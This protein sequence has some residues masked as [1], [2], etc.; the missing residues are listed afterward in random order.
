MRNVKKGLIAG[1]VIFAMSL[2]SG[3]AQKNEIQ[4]LDSSETLCETVTG[5]Q[6]ENLEDAGH[7]AYVEIVLEEAIQIL[8]VKEGCS[9]EE[10]EKR[11]AE[12]NFSIY[13]NFDQ[14]IYASMKSTYE[15]YQEN[16][17]SFASAVT[18]LNGKLIAAYSGGES[19]E[20]VNYVTT[21]TPPY[22]SFKPLSV[23]TPAIEKG[24]TNWSKAYEDSPVK[25]VEDSGGVLRDWPANAT[26][27]YTNEDMLVCEA[28]K[29]ST[30]TVA[31]KCLQEYGVLNSIEYLKERFGLF[32]NTEENMAYA[33]G[34]EEII[35]NIA[36]GYLFEGVSP[37]NMAGYYQVFANG[38][39]YEAPKTIAKICASDGSVLYEAESNMKQVLNKEVV[40]VMN[41][42]LRGVVNPGGTAD[43]IQIENVEVGGKTGTGE[44]GNW[45]VGFTPEYT[46]AVWHGKEIRNNNTDD[47]FAEMVSRFQHNEEAEYPKCGTVKEMVY[48]RESGKLVSGKCRQIDRG[49]YI[50]GDTLETCDKH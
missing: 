35:G 4:I 24:L 44:I 45:F 10:A 2:M 1:T 17:L 40:Y 33:V 25:Q 27:T 15:K 42:L 11:L 22:S 41:L 50:S 8:C 26:G 19:E 20:Y 9:L 28:I 12:E 43:S 47:M 23:Y 31:V 5:G 38:G 32:L 46:C 36:L 48:C 37:V 7:R 16:N 39:K 21:K 6:L 3:C 29:K 18:D 13:T 49:Y 34:E 14:A 30:N